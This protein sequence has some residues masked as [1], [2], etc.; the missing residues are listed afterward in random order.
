MRVKR[1]RFTAQDKAVIHYLDLCWEYHE[2]VARMN[3]LVVERLRAG[4]D[5]G[6]VHASELISG[7]K[8]EE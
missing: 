4:L 1:N 7:P 8:E 5:G 6:L 2:I 3:E